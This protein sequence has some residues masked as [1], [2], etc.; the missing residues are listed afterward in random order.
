MERR[1]QGAL[2]SQGAAHLRKEQHW[3]AIVSRSV[4]P[5]DEDGVDART[6]TVL[7]KRRAGFAKPEHTYGRRHASM[8]APGMQ[9]WTKM[10]SMKHRTRLTRFEDMSWR[11][12]RAGV[13]STG[14]A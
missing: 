1:T 4:R 14:H 5:R 7:T 10:M 8:P 12:A 3:R 11:K 2:G 9:R 13:A 6:N